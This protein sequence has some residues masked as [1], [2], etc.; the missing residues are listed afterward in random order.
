[1]TIDQIIAFVA[2]NRLR[3]IDK[4]TEILQG[5]NF[6]KNAL[7]EKRLKRQWT[8]GTDIPLDSGY[9]DYNLPSGFG[10]MDELEII[11]SASEK[12]K[13]SPAHNADEI[14]CDTVTTGYPSKYFLYSDNKIM[15]GAPVP[16][17]NLNMKPYYFAKI[18]D[19]TTGSTTPILA[20]IYGAELYIFGAESYVWDCMEQYDKAEGIRLR[21][22]NPELSRI[23]NI[24]GMKAPNY[25]K[26]NPIF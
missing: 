11:I 14:T 4:N 3:R 7:L 26:P 23:L 24:E 6:V 25:V 16:T 12:Y 2:T 8:I 13:I 5:I 19:Y 17:S 21:R 9:D 22:Y 18:D 15:V 10:I 1:M 20:D